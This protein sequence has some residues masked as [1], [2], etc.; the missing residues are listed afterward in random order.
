MNIIEFLSFIAAMLLM[1]VSMRQKSK[2]PQDQDE[3]GQAE[4]L[5]QAERLRA[6]LQ[7]VNADMQASASNDYSLR[8]VKSHSRQM[9]L[10]EAPKEPK[11]ASKSKSLSKLPP[12]NQ[13][14]AY[15]SAKESQFD[16]AQR[17]AYAQIKTKNSRAYDYVQKLKDPKEMVILHEIIGPPAALK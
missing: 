6:F 2:H 9:P 17:N 14:D 10:K 4:D 5:E 8:P 16:W 7:G 15:H 1:M 12:S 3:E 13:T 11:K